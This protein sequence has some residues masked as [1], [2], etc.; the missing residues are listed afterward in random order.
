MLFSDPFCQV[1]HLCR[2]RTSRHRS[3]I[4]CID[5]SLRPFPQKQ[6]QSSV[7]CIICA[8]FFCVRARSVRSSFNLSSNFI[9]LFRR[10][11]YGH[12]VYKSGGR[13]YRT[14]R[15]PGKKSPR[16]S[17]FTEGETQ[18]L[19]AVS[20][21][22]SVWRK[23]FFPPRGKLRDFKKCFFEMSEIDSSVCYTVT[24]TGKR[25]SGG[26]TRGA[27]RVPAPVRAAKA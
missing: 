25:H 9:N 10:N 7:T 18:L 26:I 14:G 20:G 21:A 2:L 22:K 27:P 5:G 11:F 4:C 19:S 15:M 8:N 13:F 17:P 24:E 12:N 3:K 23:Y 1:K 16:F 6:M